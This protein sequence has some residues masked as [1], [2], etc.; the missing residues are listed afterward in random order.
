MQL[1]GVVPNRRD[2]V[3]VSSMWRSPVVL[4]LAVTP[5][6]PTLGCP[7]APRP[8][9]RMTTASAPTRFDVLGIGNAIVDVLPTRTRSSREGLVKAS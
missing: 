4:H 1:V 2:L 3:R 7:A 6:L 5:V 8:E 9:E